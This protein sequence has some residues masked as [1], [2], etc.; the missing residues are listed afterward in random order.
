MKTQPLGT[1]FP[2]LLVVLAGF[3]ISTGAV[4]VEISFNTNSAPLRFA[5]E[6]IQTASTAA[7][8]LAALAISLRVDSAL[9]AQG[10]RIERAGGKIA[11]AGGDAAGAM[12]G[13][14][15]VAE[16]I[17]TGALDALKT[18][19]HAPRIAQ[20]GI[21]LNIPLDLRTPTYSDPSDAAQ[22]NI[23]EMWSLD[24]WRAFL[25]DMARHRYNVL[26]LWS[27]HPFPSIV[28]V[29]EFPDVALD[30]VWRTTVKLDANFDGN[31][32]NFVRPDMLTHHEVVKRLTIAEKIQF[33][34]DVMQLANDRG[35]VVY[36]FIWNAFLYG[37]EG[38]DGITGDA[39]A[40]RS[41][42][43]FRASVRATIKTY[44]LL[45]G[46]GITAGENLPEQIGGI[47]QGTMA[48]EN[49]R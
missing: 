35:V 31:G 20:R 9:P 29:P 33:W 3:A 34:R 1:L 42:E 12:Y 32:R 16:A 19:V 7:K 26:S 8:N 36:W 5:A 18:S 38:K 39:G 28:M 40:P 2:T 30:D 25:D 17:R 27:L 22:A 13:G 37:A 14:L 21:K 46:F 44:P 48:L 24:F 47:D 15:D 10:Y 11:V 4:E 45:A 49:L 23:P 41:I 43:Y 6:E